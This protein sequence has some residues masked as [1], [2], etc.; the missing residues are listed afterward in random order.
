MPDLG[1]HCEAIMESRHVDVLEMDAASHTGID[2]VR[3]IIDGIRYAPVAARYKVYIIDEVHMLSEKAFNAFLKT[4]E[5]PPPH[6]KFVFA[7]T[8]IRKVPVTI[9]SRCQ[10]FD[11]RRIEADKL[12]AH[13]SRIGAA[14]G[15]SASG[16]A[17]AAI[18]RAAEGSARDALSLLDQAIAHGAGNVSAETVRDML[19]LA[20]RAQVIDLF[21]AVMRGDVAGAFATLRAQ[22]DAGADP[23]VILS[24]LAAFSHVVTRLKLIPDAAKDPAL[25]EV[26]RVRGTD[27]AATLSV[28]TLSRTWQI[29]LKGIPE[30][31]AANRPIDAAEMVLVRLAYAA[32]LPTPEEALRALKDGAPVA[33]A[34]PA[35]APAPAPAGPARPTGASGNL[36][37]AS[38]QPQPQQPVRAAEPVPVIRLRRFEDVVALAAERR[39]IGLKLALERDVR[40]VRFEE[41]RI[42]FNLQEGGQRTIAN[43]LSRALQNWTGQRWVVALSAEAGEPTLRERALEAARERKEGAATHP[44][45]QAV[46]AKFPG[47]QI[48]DVRDRAALAPEGETADASAEILGDADAEAVREAEADDD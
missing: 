21:E 26:E 31:Q 25:T 1:V 38:S 29:V 13:L 9:L 8:E 35:P 45:V 47:A 33:A 19:G 23:A 32:D 46:L 10:R 17:L 20:D 18:A 30:V 14:E 7:T 22:Y 11:L 37:L 12:V 28:R 48:V 15:I 24:D 41:G 39:E 43:D 4:L 3:Q 36:A 44:L 6:A 16:E 40:L 34:G 27:F 42:E 2:D 5:E